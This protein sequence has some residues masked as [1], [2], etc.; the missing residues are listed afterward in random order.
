MKFEVIHSLKP[1]FYCTPDD[2]D[3]NFPGPCDD[4]RKKILSNIIASCTEYKNAIPP[5]KVAQMENSPYPYH[6]L[7][8]C[9]YNALMGQSLIQQFSFAYLLT[10]EKKYAEQ[11][12]RWLHA[13]LGWDYK[14]NSFYVSARVMQALVTAEDWLGSE[15]TGN[16][17]DMLHEY[18]IALCR[19]HE[20]TID[21]LRKDNSRG[22]HASLYT[23]SFGVAALSLVGVIP[24]AEKW[25]DWVIEKFE[26]ALLPRDISED[27]TYQPEG[28]WALGYSQYSK[29]LFMDALKNVTGIDL[30]KKHYEHITRAL[31]FLRYAYVGGKSLEVKSIYR[32]DENLLTGSWQLDSFSPVFLKLAS[33]AGDS[34]AQWIAARDPN[35]GKI[36]HT[37]SIVKGGVEC[38]FGCGPF[39]YL[40]YDSSVPAID[41]PDMKPS[42]F[43][44][45]GECVVMRS[46][47][48]EPSFV[49]GY[50]GR[51][52][53]NTF[54][55][56]SMLIH[57]NGRLMTCSA[58]AP[59]TVPIAEGNAPAVNG[60]MERKSKIE[61]FIS[62]DT[63]DYIKASGFLTTQE[64]ALLRG[65]MPCMLLNVELRGRKPTEVQL[66]SN[67]GEGYV[68]LGNGG[69][70]QYCRENNFNPDAGAIRVVFRLRKQLKRSHN[71][72]ILIGVG[73]GHNY[74]FSFGDSLN[75]GFMDNGLLT[76][77]LKDSEAQVLKAQIPMYSAD[78]PKGEWYE[79]IAWWDGVNKVG[80]SPRAGIML[81]GTEVVSSVKMPD[82]KAF[83]LKPNAS[84]WVGSGVQLPDSDTEVDVKQFEIFDSS[85]VE[86]GKPSLQPSNLLFSADYTKSIDAV[87]V[88]GDGRE[89]AEGQLEFYMHPYGSASIT[90][91][92]AE[93][94]NG[95]SSIS[96]VPIP[97]GSAVFDLNPIPFAQT[98][99]AGE[100]FEDKRKQYLRLS[101]K[102]ANGSRHLT[103]AVL[104]DN[105]TYS[106]EFCSGILSS[107]TRLIIDN[108]TT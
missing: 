30:Y 28:N 16:D 92:G 94:K 48:E 102:P 105:Q 15:L 78:I 38:I 2:P 99:F 72:S 71:P 9:F 39:A 25:V 108:T 20:N 65:K 82:S 37:D 84:I 80:S 56:P 7:Y 54:Q 13:L 17:L 70:L 61:K 90:Q 86:D 41:H 46:G 1:R 95:D 107:F 81:N 58:P 74:C 98:G 53:I 76:L 83:R 12:K 11:A 77:Q 62:D 50:Q 88:R 64:M 6:N 73:Q 22:A 21:V 47:W 43:F 18:N 29:Y 89:C 44:A 101:I 36:Q 79:V 59:N 8:L 26:R 32:P 31:E 5:L 51:K 23:S 49:I 67:N 33:I 68:H 55:S 63:G 35:M 93:F 97:E 69:Y 52:S 100:A 85:T 87:S 19:Q 96:I 27:G 66:R 3:F 10:R 4:M 103:L 75:L 45:K 42:R 60:E 24:E 34:Y 40:W 14:I 106:K 57:W 91:Y 104:P